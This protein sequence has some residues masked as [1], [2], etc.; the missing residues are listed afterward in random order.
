MSRTVMLALTGM[1]LLQSGC[2]VVEMSRKM[3]DYT[4]DTFTPKGTDYSDPTEVEEDPWAFVG[5]EARGE[6]P[7]EKDPDQWYRRWFM[8]AKARSIERNFG[9]E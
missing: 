7:T 5:E 4:V 1:L 6:R 2:V 8:S 9:I 3:A